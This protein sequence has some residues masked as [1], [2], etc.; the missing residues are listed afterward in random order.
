MTWN[1]MEREEAASSDRDRVGLDD[2][3][4]ISK[5]RS[6]SKDKS[7]VFRHSGDAVGVIVLM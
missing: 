2:R 4:T 3:S 6:V 1:R 5:G 7:G